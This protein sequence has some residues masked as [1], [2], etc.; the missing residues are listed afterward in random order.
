MVLNE[1]L[2]SRKE[3]LSELTERV[4]RLKA[5]LASVEAQADEIS[6]TV[7]MERNLPCPPRTRS[8]IATACSM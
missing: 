1:Q 8:N 6:N 7:V 5:N 3:Q 2:K 4:A